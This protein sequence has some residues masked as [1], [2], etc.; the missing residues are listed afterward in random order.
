MISER[1]AEAEDRAVPG[2]WEGDL[3]IGKNGRSAVG[4]LVERTTRYVLLLHLPDGR[5]ADQVEKAMRTGDPHAARRAGPHHH[6]GPGQGDGRPRRLHR[7]HRHPGLLL[8]PAQPWQRGSNENTNGLLRQYL[9][10]G[11]DLS[12]HT[13]DD[14]ARIAAQ[15]QQP[16]PQDARIHETIRKARRASC[17]HRLN[18]PGLASVD[19]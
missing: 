15:P 6:L 7:R 4:T 10:K 9:P 17:A 5:D 2:H 1:P 12:V 3:I 14:L 19:P 16:A 11:T 13:A 18:P 8:R